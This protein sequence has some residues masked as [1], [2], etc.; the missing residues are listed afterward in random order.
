MKAT[1]SSAE[2][3]RALAAKFAAELSPKTR[4]VIVTLSGDLGAGKTT[5]AQAVAKALGVQ[6]DVTS[7]TF[8]IEKIYQLRG[9]RFDHLVH[10]DAYRLEN[11]HELDVLGFK[12]LLRDPKNLILLEWPER[13]AGSLPE[14][15]VKVRFDIH[16]DERTIS[17]NG[18]EKDGTGS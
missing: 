15:A 1:T 13:I 2:E 17:I 18:E 10:I 5:F 9:Q 7:P 16:G 6:E 14:D 8:V 11:P 4:A 12:E 3:L